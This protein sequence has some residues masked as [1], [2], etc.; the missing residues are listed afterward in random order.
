M[1]KLGLFLFICILTT[2]FIGCESRFSFK[3]KSSDSQEEKS[4]SGAD[5]YEWKVIQSPIT[6]ICYEVVI[7]REYLS[8]LGFMGMSKI[9]CRYLDDK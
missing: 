2:V 6:G 7:Y 9:P 1:K 8:R 4:S 3:S 5:K